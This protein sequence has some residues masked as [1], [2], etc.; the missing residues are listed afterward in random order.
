MFGFFFSFSGFVGGGGDGWY[1]GKT[2]HLWWVYELFIAIAS[3]AGLKLMSGGGKQISLKRRFS[4][5]ASAKKKIY[6]EM[7]IVIISHLQQILLETDKFNKKITPFVF[8]I[9]NFSFFIVLQF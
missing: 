4:Y 5:S 2:F 1:I 7:F 9:L 8:N 3:D 6:I